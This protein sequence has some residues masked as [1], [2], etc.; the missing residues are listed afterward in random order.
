MHNIENS[1]PTQRHLLALCNSALHALS[2]YPGGIR[3]RIEPDLERR[4]SGRAIA[5]WEKPILIEGWCGHPL[6]IEN[7]EMPLDER[8]TDVDVLMRDYSLLRVT[9]GYRVVMEIVWNADGWFGRIE[10]GAWEVNFF[11]WTKNFYYYDDDNV[12]PAT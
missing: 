3:K 11:N 12:E 7:P 10:P 2:C 4:A 6:P 8:P 5:S 9:S 1:L